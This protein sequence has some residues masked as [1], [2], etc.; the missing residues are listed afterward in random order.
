MRRILTAVAA[1][2]ATFALT[3]GAAHAG[4]VE[5]QTRRDAGIPKSVIY[6]K[7]SAYHVPGTA[8]RPEGVSCFSAKTTRKSTRILGRNVPRNRVIR[9]CTDS[10]V[11]ERRLAMTFVRYLRYSKATA[12]EIAEEKRLDIER[13]RKLQ[14]FIDNCIAGGGKIILNICVT[15]VR[16]GQS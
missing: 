13:A 5:R 12:A 15:P 16:P 11:D 6:I 3:A 9:Y 8:F 1:L 2:I 14:E 4:P 7:G 10:Y